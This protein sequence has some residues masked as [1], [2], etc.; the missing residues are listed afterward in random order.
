MEDERQKKHELDIKAHELR[1]TDLEIKELRLQAQ[2][3]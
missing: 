3:I 2:L 1:M